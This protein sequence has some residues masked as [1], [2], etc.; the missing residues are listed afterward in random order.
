MKFYLGKLL[1]LQ[2]LLVFLSVPVFTQTK[3]ISK[4]RIADN[5]DGNC[6][7]PILPADYSDFN[8]PGNLTMRER[9]ILIGFDLKNKKSIIS[10]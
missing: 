7:N 10:S 9:L 5:G 4:V 2:I 3:N 1:C 6:K 8:R